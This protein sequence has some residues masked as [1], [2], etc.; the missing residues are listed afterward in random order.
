MLDACK[1]GEADVLKLFI[2]LERELQ[3]ETLLTEVAKNLNFKQCTDDLVPKLLS[4]AE[5]LYDVDHQLSFDFVMSLVKKYSSSSL[6]LL[7][8]LLRP[9][10][11]F[12]Q[13]LLLQNIGKANFLPSK[14]CDSHFSYISLSHNQLQHIP[15]GLFQLQF[16]VGLDLS[17][18]SLK[19]LPSVLEWNCPRLKDLDV[20]HNNLIDSANELIK[21]SSARLNPGVA[22]ITD[23]PKEHAEPELKLFKL[24]GHRFYPC[25]HSLSSVNLSNNKSLSKVPEW[26]CVL[27][28]LMFLNLKGLPK[29]HS[30]PQ[31]LA[32]WKNLLGIS[33]ESSNMKSPPTYVCS[34]G[35]P[36]IVAYLRCHMRGCMP[37]RHMKVMILGRQQSGKIT[38]YHGLSGCR[39]ADTLAGASE[40][41]SYDYRLPFQSEA[42]V[43]VT[44][45][46]MHFTNEAIRS[47]V[48]QCFLIRRCVYLFLWNIVEGKAG[49]EALMPILQTVQ[50]RVP[51]ACVVLVVTHVDKRPDITLSD[52]L[53]WEQDVFNVHDPLKLC[54][55]E[56]ASCYGLP[57]LSSPILINALSKVDIDKLKRELHLVA[58]GL[59]LDKIQERLVEQAVPRSFIALQSLVE[60]KVKQLGYQ[61]SIIRYEELMDSFHA[62]SVRGDLDD[63]EKQFSI[64]CQFLHNAGVLFCF[65]CSDQ[66]N[67]IFLNLQWLSD[68]LARVLM[69]CAQHVTNS[70]VVICCKIIDAALEK[71]KVP[72]SF[73]AVFQLLLEQQ[74]F[75][76]A[77]C[78]Q[79]ETFLMP[80]ALPII[81]PS[82]YPQCNSTCKSILIR[83]V[84]FAFLPEFY[85]SWL[86]YY[87]LANLHQLG[88][89]LLTQTECTFSV[90]EAEIIGSCKEDAPYATEHN[91]YRIDHNGYIIRQQSFD[92]SGRLEALFK[93]RAM[94][95][96]EPIDSKHLQYMGMEIQAL[97]QLFISHLSFEDH[98]SDPWVSPNSFSQCLLS[99]NRMF[100]NFLDGTSAWIE[101]NGSHHLIITTSGN[102]EATI[103]SSVFLLSC[104]EMVCNIWYSGLEKYCDLPCPV[105]QKNITEA[106]R[107][108]DS[109]SSWIPLSLVLHNLRHDAK[110]MH[111]PQCL[112]DVPLTDIAPD[113]LL[114]DFPLNDILKEE[115]LVVEGKLSKLREENCNYVSVNSYLE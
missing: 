82:Q 12:P 77:L 95:S 88:A 65:L 112:T 45:H 17:H 15:Q 85:F 61:A 76:A 41:A 107:L 29:L 74:G 50:A 89:Q 39:R 91:Q 34:Q 84:S 14:L 2:C 33:L 51:G 101:L 73:Q 97:S 54:F 90:L 8:K 109:D 98:H 93:V 27:P 62:I 59:K 69:D 24:T 100:L 86:Q 75:L 1:C 48:Y 57:C 28:N 96:V 53:S 42:N 80:L 105:C 13:H 19:S 5:L 9:L 72:V 18:N 36:A 3:L 47:S 58:C 78:A 11:M 68:V 63:D 22:C 26:V 70:N 92:V 81:P 52:I 115:K 102:V 55:N 108:S 99:K 7:S 10:N 87:I 30:L 56:Y 79:K 6:I 71:A 113:L 37:F 21:N 38:V 43:R 64:A 44:Y 111:C 4:V 106:P 104:L 103:K 83:R 20:S 60:S 32:L 67:L 110:A 23:M 40:K 16:L 66:S 46:L 94:A 35:T 49:L 25:I 31:A 114:M